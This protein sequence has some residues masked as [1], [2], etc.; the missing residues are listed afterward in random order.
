MIALST[1][2]S[3]RKRALGMRTP[4][5]PKTAVQAPAMYSPGRKSAKKQGPAERTSRGL[6]W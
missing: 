6:L 4:F 3:G 2:G 1:T 5:S